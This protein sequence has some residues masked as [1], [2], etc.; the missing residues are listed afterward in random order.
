MYYLPESKF[1][2]CK[3]RKQQ[4]SVGVTTASYLNVVVVLVPTGLP[5][6]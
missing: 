4:L 6:V 1:T 5:A 2:S 3:N